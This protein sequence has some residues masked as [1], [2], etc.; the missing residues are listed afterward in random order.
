MQLSEQQRQSSS[1][2]S[3]TRKDKAVYRDYVEIDED[4]FNGPGTTFLLPE[5]GW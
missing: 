2:P 3:Y 5:L 4:A 1:S